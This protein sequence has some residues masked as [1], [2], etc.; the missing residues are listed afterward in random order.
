M[1]QVMYKQ[2]QYSIT[3]K[4]KTYSISDSNGKEL[5]NNLLILECAEKLVTLLSNQQH[6][7][8][9]LNL[10]ELHAQYE[11]YKSDAEYYNELAESKDEDDANYYL[12]VDRAENAEMLMESVNK[13]IQMF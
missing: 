4:N 7:M 8:K 5:I 9:L 2:K 3:E 1:T 13:R 11:H 6:T 10:L 12:Y